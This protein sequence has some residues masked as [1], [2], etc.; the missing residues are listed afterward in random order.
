[1]SIWQKNMFNVLHRVR[2][3]YK[4][5]IIHTEIDCVT[6]DI[7]Y[8]IS[9]KVLHSSNKKPEFNSPHVRILGTHNCGKEFREDFKR[10]GSLQD[11]LCFHYYADRVVASFAQQ[12]QSEY[13]C[14]KL[15]MIGRLPNLISSKWLRTFSVPPKSQ[16]PYGRRMYVFWSTLFCVTNNKL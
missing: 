3:I 12:T 15:V 6:G 5:I 9:W 14:G 16:Y 10:W 7:Y 11:V 1:M 8:I 13:Y 4:C 2:N